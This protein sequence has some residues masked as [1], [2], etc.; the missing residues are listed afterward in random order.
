MGRREPDEVSTAHLQRSALALRRRYVLALVSLAL[1]AGVGGL[2]LRAVIKSHRAVSAHVMQVL[3][4]QRTLSQALCKAALALMAADNTSERRVYRG[5]IVTALNSW[6]ASHRALLQSEL[7]RDARAREHARAQQHLQKLDPEY[8]AMARAADRLLLLTQTEPYPQ[9][10]PQLWDEVDALLVHER[11]YLLAMETLTQ[12]FVRESAARDEAAEDAGLGVTAALLLLLMLEGLLIFRPVLA[13]LDRSIADLSHAWTEVSRGER[14]RKAM[15]NALPD[16]LIRYD[17]HGGYLS[18]YATSSEIPSEVQEALRGRPLESLMP[19][20]QN[21]ALTGSIEQVLAGGGV[22]RLDCA[23]PSLDSERHA[24]LR[25]VALGP[26][27]LLVLV[28][29]V[30]A[31]RRIERRVLEAVEQEQQRI[32]REL[33]DGVCQS[34]AGL[35]LLTRSLVRDVERGTEVSASQLD[36][37]ARLLEPCVV[38]ARRMARGLIP[39]ELTSQG[40]ELAL[41]R[42]TEDAAALHRITVE[43]EVNLGAYSPPPEVAHQLYRIAQEAVSNATRHG[44]PRSVNVRLGLEEDVKPSRMSGSVRMSGVSNPGISN[45]GISNPA[46][47]NSG[48]PRPELVLSVRDDGVGISREAI[49]P[50]AGEPRGLGL[51]TMAYRARCIGGYLLVDRVAAG[52]TWVRCRLPIV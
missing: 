46:I 37:V 4:Q 15:L 21:A 42:L 2:L 28:R 23:L 45:P 8:E 6:R 35:S 9:P 3:G 17:R 38:E 47:S 16:L 27:D 44:Q 43:C 49:T 29:D 20:S 40:L 19:S 5:E 51:Q 12:D 50:R 41:H 36:G 33:H 24:E 48:I 11:P 14:E 30:T 34:L 31:Q 32:G 26:D 1:L 10:K 7:M 18:A 52:G 39:V 25:I 13:Q 22:E